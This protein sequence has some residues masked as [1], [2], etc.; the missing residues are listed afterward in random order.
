MVNFQEFVD[1]YIDSKSL[2]W[3]PNTMRSERYR[4]RAV[5]TEIAGGPEAL[6]RA[7]DGRMKPYAIKT[8][9]IR[10]G[11][12]YQW[13]IATQKVTGNNI[14]KDFISTNA[15]LFKHS[16]KKESLDVDYETALE[17]IA[18][19][20][21]AATKAKALQLLFSGQ[22]YDESFSA[23]NGYIIGK[24][25]KSRRDYTPGPLKKAAT[26]DKSYHTFRRKLAEVGLKPHTLR[27]LAATQMGE[28]GANEADLLEV[29]G[30]S[31][32][33]TASRYLQAKTEEKL[34]QLIAKISKIS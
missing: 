26:Y 11:E 32:I 33:Q 7:L 3:A 8:T 2:A 12:Y 30:W 17:R 29:F 28:A 21:D 23:R 19:I 24:G 1:E 25:G 14:Y 4:L 34:D 18:E 9:F 10:V 16:Y 5:A 20:K 6:Y 22:R 13:L 31:N 27:K 15:R